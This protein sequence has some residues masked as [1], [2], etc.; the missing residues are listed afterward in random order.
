MNLEV[1]LDGRILNTDR[2]NDRRRTTLTFS[3]YLEISILK[4]DRVFSYI[5]ACSPLLFFFFFFFFE[6]GIENDFLKASYRSFRRQTR[7]QIDERRR[8]GRGRGRDSERLW[9]TSLER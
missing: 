7:R 9:R 8:R 2:R 6:G 5:A 4:K 1:K 3:K